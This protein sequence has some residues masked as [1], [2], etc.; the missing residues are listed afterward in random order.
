[1]C[2][3]CMI[4]NGEIPKNKVYED[5][6]V[7][8]FLDLSQATLGHTLVIPKKHFD[9]IY[10]LDSDTASKVFVVTQRLAKQIKTNLNAKGVNI[11]NN[12]EPAAGQS[13]NHFHIHILPRYDNDDL[14]IKFT[15]HKL[16]DQEFKDL[17][18]KI[19]K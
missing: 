11:L 12:N 6:D 4:A 15:E 1:M 19:K 16:S 7:M 9:N 2:V 13:V 18:E 10:A 5:K 3:F 17:L 8:A 14:D